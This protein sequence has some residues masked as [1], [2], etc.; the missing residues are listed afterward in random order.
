M[1]SSEDPKTSTIL[2][3]SS[4]I[5]LFMG[6]MLPLGDMAQRCNLDTDTLTE[7]LQWNIFSEWGSFLIFLGLWHFWLAIKIDGRGTD[8]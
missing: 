4:G 5:A 7:L 6:I 1:N 3:I 2:Y 8:E